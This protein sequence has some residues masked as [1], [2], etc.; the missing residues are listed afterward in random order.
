MKP[1]RLVRTY[2]S[3][4][5]NS[6]RRALS[7]WTTWLLRTPRR[8]RQ[9]SIIMSSANYSQLEPRDITG[10]LW[11]GWRRPA[12]I[13]AVVL[14]KDR[15]PGKV[16]IVVR[17]LDDKSWFVSVPTDIVEALLRT[18]Q[19]RAILA[20]ALDSATTMRVMGFKPVMEIQEGDEP[21][22]KVKVYCAEVC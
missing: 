10:K 12:V 21:P 22:F 16:E 20:E 17:Y 13:D 5:R 11:R 9:K 15:E 8:L 6:T 14:I 7:L 1:L 2:I 3:L 4:I 18:P 19:N